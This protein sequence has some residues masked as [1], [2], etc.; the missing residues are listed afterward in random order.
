MFE[1]NIGN[2]KAI[3][4]SL[5]AIKNKN[6]SEILKQMKIRDNLKTVFIEYDP[7]VSVL[8]IIKN[9]REE[10]PEL[11]IFLFEDEYKNILYEEKYHNDLFEFRKYKTAG[12]IPKSYIYDLIDSD[13]LCPFQAVYNSKNTYIN[14]DLFFSKIIT[15]NSIML[16][17]FSYIKKIARINRPVLI[18]G[19]TGS[20]KELFAAAVHNASCFKGKF[21]AVNIAGLDG[22]SFSDTLFGHVRG[23]YTG[24]DAVRKGL[25]K[26]AENGSIFLDEIGDLDNESQIKL[27]RLIDTG[28]F[29]PL[30]SDKIERSNARII[31]ATNKDL[32]QMVADGQFRED[33][34][35]RLKSHILRIPPLR[36]RMND[37]PLLV[38]SFVKK[39]SDY[40]GI[41]TPEIPLSLFEILEKYSFPGNVRE[42]KNMIYD[43]VI[44]NEGPLLESTYF[45]NYLNCQNK[46]DRVF[47]KYPPNRNVVTKD[48]DCEG[49]PTLKELSI[50]LINSALTKANGNQ[51]EAAKMLGITPSA[52]NKRMKRNHIDIK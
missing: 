23:A 40:I 22:N 3:V 8:E 38:K 45:I 13:I 44:K 47:E 41:K 20:G 18:L 35:F 10:Y 12:N 2:S 27:L 39:A 43:A 24:A 34:L 14:S 29:Y 5:K 37:I 36:E 9:I 4:I 49:F 19:E 26:S 7:L 28:E 48:L 6:I 33:L 15:R 21:V 1:T 17:N 16:D 46:N 42:L 50:K 51:S 31:T 32:D 52:L 11:S 25:L 30:G